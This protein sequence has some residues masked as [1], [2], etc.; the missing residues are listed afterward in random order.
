MVLASSCARLTMRSASAAASILTRSASASECWRNQ[1][2]VGLGAQVLG[3][4]PLQRGRPRQ[5]DLHSLLGRGL[6]VGQLGQGLPP[7]RLCLDADLRRAPL[8]LGDEG[9]NPQGRRRQHPFGAGLGLAAYGLRLQPGRGQ[10]L[11]G[12]DPGPVENTGGI[13]LA[14][15]AQ[16]LE[17][18][19]LAVAHLSQLGASLIP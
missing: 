8:G 17:L 5:R 13:L 12:L 16:R 11:R 15:A 9:L 4:L 6:R 10:Q 14:A 3:G 19:Q 2:A 7:L 1:A 18:T